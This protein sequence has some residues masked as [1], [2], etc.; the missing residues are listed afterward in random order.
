M[1]T[2]GIHSPIPVGS[3]EAIVL[4]DRIP[5]MHGFCVTDLHVGGKDET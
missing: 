3:H 4:A 5:V 2:S 1:A